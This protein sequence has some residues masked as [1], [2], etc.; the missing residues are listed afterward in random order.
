V[1]PRIRSPSTLNKSQPRM[2][3]DFCFQLSQFL[4][5]VFDLHLTLIIFTRTLAAA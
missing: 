4:L 5:C 3:T 1:G 2:D